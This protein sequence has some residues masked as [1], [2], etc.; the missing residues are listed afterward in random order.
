LRGLAA[1]Y[2]VIHHYQIGRGTWW[3]S[4]LSQG[5][6]AVM[7]FF[8]VS[9]FVIYYSMSKKSE[10]SFSKY[11]KLRF[12][13]IYFVLIFALIISYLCACVRA[14]KMINVEIYDLVLNLFNV[15]DMARH[16]GHIVSGYMQNDPLWSLTYEW[17]FYM[18]FF[19]INK[20]VKEQ[21]QNILV[22]GLSIFGI[23]SYWIYP[24]MVSIVFWYFILWW[25]GVVIAKVFV[26]KK[27][28]YSLKNLQ[29]IP[30]TFACFMV[31]MGAMNYFYSEDIQFSLHPF[32]QLRH[33]IYTF[34]IFAFGWFWYRYKLIGFNSLIMPF[35]RLAPISYAIY[36]IHYPIIF[37]M[38]NSVFDHVWVH[39]VIFTIISFILAYLIE[40][41]LYNAFNRKVS[42]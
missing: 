21:S 35:A 14:G 15:Q 32:I 29:Y 9:G 16:P 12:K 23:L 33:F 17:W 26:H 2:V 28:Q 36:V 13:R 38:R 41:I 11:F 4:F 5:Q 39:Y 10:L 20:Y 24:N 27:A 37:K 30:I 1:I 31:L 18:I 25:W 6:A 8:L 42:F 34:S 22:F 7:L 40:K 3:G 19:P